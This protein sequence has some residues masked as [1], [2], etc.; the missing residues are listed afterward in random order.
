MNVGVAGADTGTPGCSPKAGYI[1]GSNCYDDSEKAEYFAVSTYSQVPSARITAA[2]VLFYKDG[3]KGTGGNASTPVNLKLY[4]GTLAG[5]PTGTTTPIGTATANIG[6]IIRVFKY[7]FTTPIV[8]PTTN[9]FFASVVVPTAAG[10][11]AVIMDNRNPAAGTAWELWSDNTW[12]SISTAWTGIGPNG[13]AICPIMTCPTDVKSQG[14]LES[15]IGIMP[16]PTSGLI[17]VA[18]ALPNMMDLNITVTNTLG[19]II[20]ETNFTNVTNNAFTV[21]LSGKDNGVYF[22]SISN[23]T[24]KVVRKVIL[25]K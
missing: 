24:E 5:G 1:F 15:S 2:M 4:N 22:V 6:L 8:A 25:T 7:N 20:S 11:T 17:T 21:D 19:Q 23:G 18:A 10:D 12:H 3:T 16:N 14:V 13:L 9:G